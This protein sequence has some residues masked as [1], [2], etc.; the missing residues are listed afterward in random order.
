M[1]SAALSTRLCLE[2]NSSSSCLAVG[3]TSVDAYVAYLAAIYAKLKRKTVF[4]LYG[5]GNHLIFPFYYSIKSPIT[6]D[7]TDRKCRIRYENRKFPRNKF[8]HERD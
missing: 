5:F 6:M 8:N 3:G 7:D 2:W 1:Q 4:T